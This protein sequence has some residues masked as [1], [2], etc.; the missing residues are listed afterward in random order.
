MES[1]SAFIATDQLPTV[2]ETYNTQIIPKFTKNNT[3]FLQPPMIS[4]LDS[5]M[6]LKF[7]PYFHVNLAQIN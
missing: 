3:T 4:K 5:Y 6:S 2:T 1:Y 7:G